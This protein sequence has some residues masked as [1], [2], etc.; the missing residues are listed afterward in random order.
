MFVLGIDP[1]L[2]RTGYGVLHIGSG[3][4]RVVAGGVLRTDHREPMPDRLAELH[5]DL[6]ALLADLA[7]TIMALERVFIKKNITNAMSVARASGV[8]MLAAAQAGI[9]VREYTPTAV[10]L[11]VAGD[12][13]A[14]KE[15][16]AAMVVRRLGLAEAP[17]PADIADALA[18]ALCHAQQSR[19]E[20][21]VS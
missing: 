14:S 2:T 11:A 7:P 19:I 5:E 6:A 8:A 18:V 12:G 4:P 9:P 21:A 20:S 13:T 10:K 3:L 16:V 1:G 15:Q 17:K